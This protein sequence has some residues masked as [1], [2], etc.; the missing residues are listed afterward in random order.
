M[1]SPREPITEEALFDVEELGFDLPPSPLEA[2]EAKRQAKELE[3]QQAIVRTPDERAASANELI[4]EWIQHVKSQGLS[5]TDVPTE[6]KSRVGRSIR[7]LIKKGYV[8]KEIVFALSTFTV[9]DL[10]N[11]K[12]TPKTGNIEIY[13][14]QYRGESLDER[15]ANDAAQ[16]KLR[17]DALAQG[18]APTSG[19]GR[20]NQRDASVIAV[21]EAAREFQARKASHQGITYNAPPLKGIE[22]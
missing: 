19:T 12:Y 11:R 9:R 3:R 20:Q 1:V 2:A 6:I 5:E 8:Y 16:E 13:A 15:E 21:A 14:R 17:Q 10:R 4:A 7:S 18:K 22:Q